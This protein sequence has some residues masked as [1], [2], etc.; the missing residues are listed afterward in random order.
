VTGHRAPIRNGQISH[1]HSTWDHLNQRLDD[2]VAA[3]LKEV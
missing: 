3:I 1:S 2:I